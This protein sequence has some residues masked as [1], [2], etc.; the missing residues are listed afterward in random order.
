MTYVTH[1]NV[2]T[3]PAVKRRRMRSFYSWLRALASDSQM[4]WLKLILF[5]PS[6]GAGEAVE[7]AQL[8]L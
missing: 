5:P 8:C 7:R 3:D 6:E 1:K 2:D 4:G